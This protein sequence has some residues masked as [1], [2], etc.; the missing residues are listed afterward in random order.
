VTLLINIYYQS[1]KILHSYLSTLVKC[2]GRKEE[3]GRA[4]SAYGGE[5][6]CVRS[7]DVET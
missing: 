5:E 7:L 3:M 1:D 4:C 6:R 2:R